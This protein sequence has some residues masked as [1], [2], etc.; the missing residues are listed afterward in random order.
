M[1]HQQNEATIIT[2]TCYET[3]ENC[4]RNLELVTRRV[5]SNNSN[6]KGCFDDC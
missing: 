3:E 1:I 5:W 2:Q 4:H 6:F